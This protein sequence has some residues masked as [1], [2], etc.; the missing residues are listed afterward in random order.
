[1]RVHLRSTAAV[2][3]LFLVL[4]DAAA[5]ENAVSI[6][7]ML[8]NSRDPLVRESA[9]QVLGLRGSSAAVRLLVGCLSGDDALWVRARCAEALGRIGDPSSIH[10]LNSALAR[11]KNQRVRRMIAQ[12]LVR[13]GQ[14]AGINELMW[15]LKAGTNHTKAEVMAFLIDM[16]GQPLGQD[17]DAWWSHL[18]DKGS[19]SLARRPR[20]SPSIVEM[21]GAVLHLPDGQSWLQ[22]P[23]VVLDLASG[24]DLI[25]ERSLKTY[26]R[27]NGALP[28]GCLLLL[29]TERSK[30]N[31]QIK[32]KNRLSGPGMSLDAAR[33]LLHRLPN[34]VGIGIDSQ[35]LDPP[36]SKEVRRF[37]LSRKKVVVESLGDMDRIWK[38]GTRL[39]LLQPARVL[40]ILP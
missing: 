32:Q 30:K 7:S 11:E 15:Q 23:A 25:T 27:R 6:E 10:P 16:L 14:R 13:L 34:L 22:V 1:M 31:P 9:A 37:L 4:S 38:N 35:N 18:A 8:A 20:G 17:V 12:A 24:R 28:D 3:A 33:Y 26:E 21:G 5:K 19:L 40:A 2:F 39:L 36:G 29:R